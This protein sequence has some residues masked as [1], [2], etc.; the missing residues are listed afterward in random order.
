MHALKRERIQ[1]RSG[2]RLINC[3][4]NH[5][6]NAKNALLKVRNNETFIG[7]HRLTCEDINNENGYKR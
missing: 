1:R 7:Q 6:T 3:K 5:H 4:Y 2:N